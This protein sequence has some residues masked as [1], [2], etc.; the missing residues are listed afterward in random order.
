MKIKKGLQ[1]LV[2][3]LGKGKNMLIFPNFLSFLHQ[4]IARHTKN[5]EKGDFNQCLKCAAPNFWSKYTI[6]ELYTNILNLID[7]PRKDAW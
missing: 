1:S 4:N 6:I 7:D 2:N 5:T 3:L